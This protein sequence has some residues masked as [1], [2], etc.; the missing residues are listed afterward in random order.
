M[1]NVTDE[2]HT[3]GKSILRRVISMAT[4]SPVSAL[5]CHLMLKFRFITKAKMAASQEPVIVFA[6]IQKVTSF[7][8]FLS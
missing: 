4:A 2:E 7:F 6:F 3:G 8:T 5:R 1:L